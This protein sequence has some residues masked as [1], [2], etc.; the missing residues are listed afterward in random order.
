MRNLYHADIKLDNAIKKL[1]KDPEILDCN[2]RFI[3]K[4]REFQVIAEISILRQ[5][6][7]LNILRKIAPLLEVSFKK[8]DQHDIA[9]LIIWLNSTGFK[10][11]TKKDYKIVFKSF[12]KF[13]YPDKQKKYINNIRPNSSNHTTEALILTQTEIQ[14]YL[15]L[16]I[17]T[18][19]DRCYLYILIRSGCRDGEILNLKPVNVCIDSIGAIL[20]VVGKTGPRDVRI[21]GCNNLLINLI[22]TKR[23]D[24]YLFPHSINYYNR[25]I[26]KYTLILDI[27][28]RVYPHLFR[29][30]LLSFYLNNGMSIPMA[31]K[32]FGWS[33]TSRIP[34]I[35]YAHSTQDTI[36]TTI[37]SIINR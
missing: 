34:E 14:Q 23:R 22:Q 24:E 31:K 30:T 28:K 13:L 10:D 20:Y 11:S 15:D 21:Y 37:Q 1:R 36:D 33:K 4:Y 16:E 2:K 29:H 8:T 3:L 12:Y 7:C 6:K 19:E 35:T 9:K 18:L 17:Q 25:R 27:N 5:Y 26:K 32:H